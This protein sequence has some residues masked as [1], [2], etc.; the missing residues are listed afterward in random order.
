MRFKK[1]F[2]INQGFT[3]IELLIVMAVIGILVTISIGSFRSSQLKARDAQRKSDLTQ[4]GHALEAYF[5]DKGQYPDNS[6]AFKIDGCEDLG[7]G[8]TTCEWGEKWDDEHDTVYMIE[9]PADPGTA[10]LNYYY[11]SNGSA[12]QLY[13]RLENDQD[14]AIPI[15]DDDP[16]NYGISCG[17]LNCNYGVASSNKTV[18]D[19]RTITAD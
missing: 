18:T 2:S 12:Y 10:G 3:L 4:I 11:L 5:N 1:E 8:P 16:A 7:A 15:L 6:A 19:G 17:E 14:G 13:A 9:L